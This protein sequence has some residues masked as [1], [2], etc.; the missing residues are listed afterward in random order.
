MVSAPIIS[1]PV[2]AAIGFEFA[3]TF[4]SASCAACSGSLVASNQTVPLLALSAPEAAGTIGGTCVNCVDRLFAVMVVSV[5]MSAVA[6]SAPEAAGEIVH[7][8]R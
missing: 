3:A 4:G 8:V 5:M 7:S 2:A 6:L 1:A